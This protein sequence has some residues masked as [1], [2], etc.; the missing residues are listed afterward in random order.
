MV[1]LS[2]VFCLLNPDWWLFVWG[3]ATWGWGPARKVSPAH[4]DYQTQNKCCRRRKWRG[5]VMF[6]TILNFMHSGSH[7]CTLKFIQ[8]LISHT[9]DKKQMVYKKWKRTSTG[10]PSVRLGICGRNRSV[11]STVWRT[12][13]CGLWNAGW[14]LCRHISQRQATSASTTITF[15]LKYECRLSTKF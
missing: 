2:T 5:D 13:C 6:W 3:T 7:M 15:R 11:N 10:T 8:I 9:C 1:A 4:I 14:W 12:L